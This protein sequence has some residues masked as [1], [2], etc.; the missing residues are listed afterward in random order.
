MH[1]AT[2]ELIASGADAEVN[3]D[4]TRHPEPQELLPALDK[5]RA[6]MS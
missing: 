6:L 3:P 2:D 4:Y 5:A 1:R